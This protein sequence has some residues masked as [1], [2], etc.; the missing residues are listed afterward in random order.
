MVLWARVPCIVLWGCPIFGSLAGFQAGQERR[1]CGNLGMNC[2]EYWDMSTSGFLSYHTLI[3]A[4]HQEKA[5]PPS[6]ET[7]FH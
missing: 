6:M 4:Y 7:V 2:K 1:I 5:I 3:D